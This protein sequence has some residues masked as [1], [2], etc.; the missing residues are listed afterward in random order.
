VT[1]FEKYLERLGSIHGLTSALGLLNWDQETMMPGKAVYCR[2]R[3]NAVLSGLVHDMITDNKFG[4]LL[5]EL[6][7]QKLNSD[8]LSSVRETKRDR[9]RAV[10]VPRKLVEEL[11]TATTSANQSWVNARKENNWTL[12][13]PDLQKIVK[14]RKQQAEAI[15]YDEEPYD[16]LLQEYEPGALTSNLVKLFGDLR[17]QLVPL[18]EKITAKEPVG[19]EN[20]M[21]GNFDPALQQTMCIDLLECIG[22][23][24]S[25]GRLD[26]S[27]HPFTAEIGC[28]ND[29]RLTVAYN[30]N[31]L[32]PAL[33]SAIHEGGHGL[34]EQGL[35]DQTMGTPLSEAVS[36]GIHES[37][38]R[39]W[40]NM[41]GRS[42]PFSV[43]LHKRLSLLFPEHFSGSTAENLYRSVNVVKQSPIRIEADELTY[44]LHI[45]LRMEL[46]RALIRGDI[47]VEDLPAKW[48]ESM[49]NYLGI[50]PAS[51]SEGVLQDIHWSAGAFGYFP[52]Y[53]LGNLYS[54]QFMEAAHI[55][56][57][58]LNSQI[59][60]GELLPLLHWMRNN[61]HKF[62]RKYSA[63]ELCKNATGSELSIAPF[64]NYLTT[65]YSEL[66]SL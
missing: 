14:L 32:G 57:P 10:K 37:Q 50:T 35:L 61:I 20:L 44:N 63:E 42:K 65:K 53:T 23:D 59:E 1:D 41:I 15:G 2:G 25:G 27:A 46:E 45:I 43:D 12:F 47:N 5:E 64:V 66:Y 30:K 48:N 13:A 29:V 26:V 22:F 34:Y 56:I 4:D 6:S 38:S 21:H 9:D 62:G 54:A 58:D 40:E 49:Q 39:L 17:N 16:A 60:R 8:Q 52:T 33:Y 24:F 31:N 11:A 18:L 19:F 3:S 28:N 51:D 55:S 36:L 7:Q